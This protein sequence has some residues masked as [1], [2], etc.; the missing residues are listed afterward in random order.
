M[1]A[2]DPLTRLAVAMESLA[3]GQLARV[4]PGPVP[5]GT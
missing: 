5:P 4:A 2:T 1:T 3:A